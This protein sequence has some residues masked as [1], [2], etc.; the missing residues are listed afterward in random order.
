ME[1]EEGNNDSRPGQAR[2]VDEMV[3]REKYWDRFRRGPN[4]SR[5]R[6]KHMKAERLRCEKESVGGRS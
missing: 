2:N 6:K 1:E 5:K 4:E 3:E